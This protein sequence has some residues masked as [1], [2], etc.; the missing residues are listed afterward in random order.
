MAPTDT[1]FAG[2]LE[3]LITDGPQEVQRIVTTLMNLA[4]RV[5]REQ[6]LGAGHYERDAERRGYANG[7]KSKKLD[8][9]AGTL[10]LD[11]P[12]TA[13]AD[14]PFYPQ[15]LERG[16][17]SCRA[18]MLAA[19]EMYVKGVSTRD[20]EKV[21][22]EFGI[23]GMSSMQVA[24]TG[25]RSRLAARRNYSIPTSKPGVSARLAASNMYSSTRDTRRPANTAS[26]TTV[27]C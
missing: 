13:G 3:H 14:E 1:T 2:I 20:V 9:T 11:I 4:M 12:K 15:S 17:R 22:A 10:R 27:P 7:Y 16:R 19:A 23:E 6:F 25:M 21:L 8:T 26:Q 18:V 5:E 24:I